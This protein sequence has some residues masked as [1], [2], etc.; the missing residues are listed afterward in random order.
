ML[1]L[2]KQVRPSD[3]SVFRTELGGHDGAEK[4]NIYHH[5]LP[6]ESKV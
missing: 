2:Y 4:G 5:G 6:A 1:D 3:T